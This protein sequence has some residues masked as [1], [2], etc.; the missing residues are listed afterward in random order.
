MIFIP[1]VTDEA[2]G[3][4]GQVTFPKVQIQQKAQPRLKI[5]QWSLPHPCNCLDSGVIHPWL[6]SWETPPVCRTRNGLIMRT[7][8]QQL[9]SRQHLPHTRLC[10]QPAYVLNHSNLG[11]THLLWSSFASWRIWGPREVKQHCPNCKASKRG[12]P[13]SQS[14]IWIQHHTLHHCPCGLTN[15][16]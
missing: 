3:L 2:W 1:H 9:A 10:S 8:P 7:P 5:G 14:S 15:T 12:V 6:W 4:E 11:C 13:N 16:W